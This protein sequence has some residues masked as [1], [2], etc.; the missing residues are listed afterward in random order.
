M[1]SHT[2]LLSVNAFG[3]FLRLIGRIAEDIHET[4]TL[5][6]HLK[7]LRFRQAVTVEAAYAFGWAP[8]YDDEDALDLLRA[9]GDLQTHADIV[10]SLR[11]WARY[12]DPRPE[13]QVSKDFGSARN[14]EEP[15]P[16]WRDRLKA[17]MA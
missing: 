5:A 4:K 6:E 17:A 1:T 7:G 8:E 14:I 15:E 9:I 11:R 10:Q 13:D 12:R 2:P 16:S 3:S